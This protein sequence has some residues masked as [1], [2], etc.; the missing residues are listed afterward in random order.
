M[1][2]KEALDYIASS[3]HLGTKLGLDNIREL[4][5]RL[6]NPQKSL[7]F[8]HVA[9]TNGK[10]SCCAMLSSV[11]RRAGCKT[12]LY[13]SPYIFRFNER[14]Q[15]NSKQIED[16]ALASLIEEVKPAAEAM[17]NQPTVF[18]IITAAALLWFARE[19]CDIVVLEVGLG[20]RF[21]AT[22]II[23]CPELAVIMNIGLDHTELL[24]NTLE[25][26]AFEKAG[27][28][29]PGCE[30]VLYNQ[31][32]AVEEVIRGICA[33][34]GSPLR[35]ADF[36]AIEP[37]FN[38]LEGQSFSY[39]GQTYALPLL[40]AHQLKNAAVVIEAVNALRERGWKIEDDALE[41]GLY[42]VFWPARFEI[43]AEEPYF[44]VDGGHNPQCA[45]TVVQNLAD[46][47]PGFRH[48]LLVGVLADKDYP[49]LFKILNLAA[50]EY[51]CV[52]PESPR[53]LPASSLAEHLKQYGKPVTVC[54]SIEDGV[55][56]AIEK[57]G[58]DGMVCAVG[59]LYMTGE[60]RNCLGLY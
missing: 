16:G 59:S 19:G 52:T 3:E 9:G 32:S 45:S 55:F 29:K 36:S 2:Y 6:G 14:M 17:E 56:T 31:S 1:N 48:V 7:R 33:E 15:I 28:I 54:Q 37:G 43:C 21:D 47:F 60:I 53:A 57:A 27:I 23:D 41:H 58:S 20:G 30:T 40:G 34:R 39:K 46:Y 25:Q 44:V 50:G 11:L 13:T 22:N 4:L 18:E 38:S 26:I 24:G 51:V 42:S 12:G 10:G 8:V 5:E 49:T 35:I